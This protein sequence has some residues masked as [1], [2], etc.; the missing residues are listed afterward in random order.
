MGADMSLN[1][2]EAN[3][4]RLGWFIN[5]LTPAW[6]QPWSG[7]AGAEWMT[8]EFFVDMARALDR[9]NFDVM[10]LEDSTYV[11]DIF[12][13]SAE[14]ELTFTVRAPKNDPLPLIPLL[15]AATEQ[16]GFVATMSTS[17]YQPFLLARLMTTLDHLTDGRVGW[18]IVT[19]SGYLAAQNFGMDQLPPH[20]E[21]YEI[22]EEFVEVVTKLWESWDQDA[23]VMDRDTGTYVDSGRVRTIDHHGRFFD[24][25]GPLNALPPLQGRPPIFQAGGSP[26]GRS[27]AAKHADTIV[28]SAK[29]VDE[30]RQYR[31][32]VRAKAAEFGRNPDDIRILYMVS[33]FLEETDEL[34]ARRRAE[35][36]AITDERARRRLLMMSD[37]IDLGQFS[38]DEPL[39]ALE[40]DGSKSILAAFHKWGA[41]RPLRDA[42]ASDEFEAVPLFGTPAT[43]ADEMQHVFEEVGGDGF[44]I[45]AGGGGMI[46]RRYIDQVCDG[47]VPELQRRGLV[48]STRPDGLFKQRLLAN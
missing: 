4:M 22:A 10:M 44:L 42:A 24:V 25:R 18:N 9:A 31:D 11:S 30:M 40:T 35:R 27:F 41:G 33:P 26:Q 14:A 32:E 36:L 17:F 7:N 15:A 34:A 29:G 19:S 20:D 47:L 1:T 6:N 5:Y 46:T 39:P 8:G 16:L 28:S 38:L 3:R 23:V 45:F 12:G 2:T 48:R 13:G 43:V 37:E 21:R